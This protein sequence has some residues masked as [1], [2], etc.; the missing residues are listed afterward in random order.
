MMIG[1]AGLPPFVDQATGAQA[2]A[3]CADV[4]VVTHRVHRDDAVRL[5]ILRAQH[6]TGA[7]RV[8]R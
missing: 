7:D 3:P 2:V 4:D 1:I 6:D 8:N 5:A